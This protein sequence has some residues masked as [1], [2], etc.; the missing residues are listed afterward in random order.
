MSHLFEQQLEVRN[1]VADLID[2]VSDLEDKD[3]TEAI[4]YAI[5]MLNDERVR[6]SPEKD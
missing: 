4:D 6:C 5:K 2:K 1:L 3:K